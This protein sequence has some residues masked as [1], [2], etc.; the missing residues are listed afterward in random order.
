MARLAS[1]AKL[2]YYPTPPGIVAH[3]KQALALSGPGT[4]RCLDS[5]CGEG[6]ALAPLPSQTTG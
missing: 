3:L 1:Q 2:G 4:Y 6:E 5:C